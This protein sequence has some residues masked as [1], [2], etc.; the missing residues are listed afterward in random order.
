MAKR[1]TL[2]DMRDMESNGVPITIRNLE[3]SI[4]Q[5]LPNTQ[6]GYSLQF[7]T[8]VDTYGLNEALMYLKLQIPNRDLSPLKPMV[9][10]FGGELPSDNK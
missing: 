10:F 5:L 9:E 6:L 4:E 1:I 3:M 7:W 8:D 2:T